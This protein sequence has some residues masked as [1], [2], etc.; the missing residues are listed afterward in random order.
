M[1]ANASPKIFMLNS[2]LEVLTTEA[3]DTRKYILA[4]NGGKEVLNINLEKKL[5]TGLLDLDLSGDE[6]TA[7][8]GTQAN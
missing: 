1:F 7:A 8:E 6:S 5:T 4:G 2:F 3:K